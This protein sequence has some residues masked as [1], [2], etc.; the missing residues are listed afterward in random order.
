MTRERTHPEATR[1]RDNATNGSGEGSRVVSASVYTV[2][3]ARYYDP[4][5]NRMVIVVPNK[6][7]AEP[8]RAIAN[9]AATIAVAT[10][11][12]SGCAPA[13]PAEYAQECLRL[14]R[15]RPEGTG[16]PAPTPR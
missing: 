14:L 5:A 8:P 15:E 12:A 16:I 1:A 10:T 4:N 6:P 2:A 9:A 11:L 7:T 3:P 13:V